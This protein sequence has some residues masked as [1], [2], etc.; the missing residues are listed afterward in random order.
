MPGRAMATAVSRKDGTKLETNFANTG[1]QSGTQA[2]KSSPSKNSTGKNSTGARPPAPSTKS[3]KK[4]KVDPEPYDDSDDSED[5]YEE[6]AV[7]GGAQRSGAASGGPQRLYVPS[8]PF[9]PRSFFFLHIFPSSV[10]VSTSMLSSWARGG[11]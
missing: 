5:D 11:K 1:R 3:T 6:I 10:L 4:R 8:A 9:L 7:P 2:N